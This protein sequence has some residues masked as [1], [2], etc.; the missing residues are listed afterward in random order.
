MKFGSSNHLTV[1]GT[2]TTIWKGGE[3]LHGSRNPIKLVQNGV[4]L[5]TFSLQFTKIKSKKGLQRIPNRPYSTTSPER[6][7]RVHLLGTGFTSPQN[8][9]E[10]SCISRTPQNR[11]S[12]CKILSLTLQTLFVLVVRKRRT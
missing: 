8:I 2:K 9:S 11:L 5:S 1:L 7:T 4:L 6:M 3:V 10:D 12:G